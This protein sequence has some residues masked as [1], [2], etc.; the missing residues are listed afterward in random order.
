MLSNLAISAL[1]GLAAAV[2]L[3]LDPAKQHLALP[4]AFDLKDLLARD[5]E[6]CKILSE[7]YEAKGG[8]PNETVVLDVPPSVGIACLKSVPLDKKRDLEL[9]DYLIPFVEFQSTLEALADPPEEYLIPGVDVLGGIEVIRTKLK[10]DEYSRQ[11]DMLKD[12]RSLVRNPLM[13]LNLQTID[14]CYSLSPRMMGTLVII[15][16]CYMS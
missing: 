8:M 11:Y 6:P 9:L 12:L 3:A 5:E 1:V 7:A 10:K 13:Q 15:V 14:P 4:R 2:P 16:L